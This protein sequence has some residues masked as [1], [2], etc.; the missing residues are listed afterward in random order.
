MQWP[1]SML[2]IATA[3]AEICIWILNV[4]QDYDWHLDVNKNQAVLESERLHNFTIPSI[5]FNT[6]KM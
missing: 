3:E 4:V 6:V 1:V 5:P 2:R